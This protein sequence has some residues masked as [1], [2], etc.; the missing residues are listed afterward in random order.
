MSGSCWL[1]Y[2]ILANCDW[3]KGTWVFNTCCP[4]ILTWSYQGV[5]SV[6][7]FLP[8]SV[9]PPLVIISIIASGAIDS[10]VNGSIKFSNASDIP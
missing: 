9:T 1:A 5:W 6:Q 4:A 10:E 8:V 3:E 2:Q 7:S